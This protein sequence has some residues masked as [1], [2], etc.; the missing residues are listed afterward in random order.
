MSLSHSITSIQSFPS[1]VLWGSIL[2]PS[3]PQTSSEH[4]LCGEAK[5]LISGILLFF[6][7]WVLTKDNLSQPDYLKT[8][9][10]CPHCSPSRKTVTPNGASWKSVSVTAGLQT[11]VIALEH[12]D[13]FHHHYPSELAPISSC[14]ALILFWDAHSGHPLIS[15]LAVLCLGQSWPGA[16][17]HPVVLWG[18]C[19]PQC[20][21]QG[22]VPSPA[23]ADLPK[24]AVAGQGACPRISAC[25]Q[26]LFCIPC[27]WNTPVCILFVV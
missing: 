17:Q 22:W 13:A 25:T 11:L 3:C 18:F 21:G 27:S 4:L 8:R 16:L 19:L 23:G 26:P 1:A 7:L 10:L 2:D 12:V 5:P 24:E 20:Q 14:W 15:A 9:G 6:L